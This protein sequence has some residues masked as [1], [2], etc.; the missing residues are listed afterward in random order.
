[1][2]GE[3]ASLTMSLAGT[4]VTFEGDAVSEAKNAPA[5]PESLYK[6]ISKLGGM[7]YSLKAEDFTCET[8]G[9]SFMT[10]SQVNAL[11]RNTVSLL[12]HAVA[13]SAKRGLPRTAETPDKKEAYTPKKPLKT[14]IF[15]RVSAFPESAFEKFDV[16]FL[17]EIHV[18][19]AVKKHGAK[20]GFALPLWLTDD[21]ADKLRSELK[22]FAEAG[23]R[24]TLAHSYSEIVISREAGLLPIASERLNITNRHAAKV[25]SSM[26]AEY[27]ILSPELK[28]GAV[29]DIT[30]M[31]EAD[32]GCAVYGN[33][34][35]MMLRRCIMSDAGCSG[36]CM[37]DGCLLPRTISD[38]KGTQLAIIP[39]GERMNILLNPH[40][41]W[42]ADRNDFG[43]PRIRHFIFT[44]ESAYEAEKVIEAYEKCLSPQEAGVTRFKRM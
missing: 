31:D 11:R 5:S 7:P 28:T 29:R 25:V 9:A 32:C 8:D 17:T 38:R 2:A 16:V 39:I 4:S 12:E 23:G 24:Y 30:A 21:G 15:S 18:A 37:G 44:T 6:N 3:N 36:K 22:K 34:P 41:L 42:C 20:V 27:V 10:A 26:G 19:D 33:T 43:S 13:E 1:V 14:A 40:P 35:L